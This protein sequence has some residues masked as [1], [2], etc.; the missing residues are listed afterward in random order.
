MKRRKIRSRQYPFTALFVVA[1]A[2]SA[3]G[4]ESAGPDPSTVGSVRVIPSV[5]MLDD[6][7]MSAQ[8]EAEALTV[9]GDRIPAQTFEWS[10]ANLGIASVS[11]G[12]TVTGTGF[13]TTTITA[14]SS[15]KSG[16]TVVT[17]R[18]PVVS[19][20]VTPGSA[21]I[22]QG[23]T[24]DLA[25]EARD[26]RGDTIGGRTFAWESTDPAIA[27]V[28]AAGRVMAI[29]EGTVTVRATTG[30]VSGSA[31]ITASTLPAGVSALRCGDL[32]NASIDQ[33][34]EID[35]FVFSGGAGDIVLVSLAGI[36]GL[37]VDGTILA[38]DG[39]RLDGFRASQPYR[40]TLPASG[41]YTVRV[42][43]AT[44]TSTA[45]YNI[46]LE[47]I[48]PAGPIDA[49]L[50]PRSLVVGDITDAGEIEMFTFEGNG[51]DDIL[52]PIAG[53]GGVTVDATL[54][55]PAGGVLR[56]F[57]A[58]T[59]ER[60]TLPDTGVYTIYVR[61]ATFRNQGSYNLGLER[62]R[63]AGAA[64]GVLTRGVIRTDTIQTV[65]DVDL[66]QF[67][68]QAGTTELMS[69][70]NHAG[71]VVDATINTPGGT[72]LRT[73]RAAAQQDIALPESGIYSV[74]V[75]TATLTFSAIYNISLQ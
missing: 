26:S 75:H 72:V 12:G 40:L 39:T 42:N 68:G 19:V 67:D 6:I 30:G 14:T 21:T 2:A 27:Q 36:S 59:I 41:L 53:T 25:A 51:G 64:D 18:R 29:G 58:H 63:P 23:F 43:T 37:V 49:V 61:S 7:G 74:Y 71:V 15:G 13:G 16:S 60:L 46:G 11:S 44:L 33:A 32:L 48:L 56:T 22:L 24:V 50:A 3:C 1:T 34:A 20:T 31:T 4:E 66:L 62:L 54:L 52:I 73:L 38:P 10:S 28:N 8:V 70:A 35:Q 9:G 17:V 5:V 55:D 47:C 45:N 65:G 57:R 69:L